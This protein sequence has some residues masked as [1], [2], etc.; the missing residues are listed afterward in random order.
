[1]RRFIIL[2]ALFAG[3]AGLSP[4]S[5]SEALPSAFEKQLDRLPVEFARHTR[6]HRMAEIEWNMRRQ[7]RWRH[8]YRD[9]GY[10]YGYGRRYGGP[11]P[12]APAYGYRRQYRDWVDD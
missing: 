3:A 5:A 2:A 1:M 6:E 10:G 9:D 4:A 8:R 7:D 11:P 12:W